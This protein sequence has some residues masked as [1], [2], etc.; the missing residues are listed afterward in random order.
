MKSIL[1]LLVAL[2]HSALIHAQNKDIDVYEKKDGDKTIVIA[3]NTSK[4]DYTV[5]LKITSEG[6]DIVPSANIESV[7]PAGMMKEMATITPRPGEAWSYGLEVSY[8]QSI[9]S[10][11]TST[12][13]T[14]TTTTTTK[15]PATLS[16]PKKPTAPE[17]SNANI[18]LYSK[19]GCSR[20]SF[21]KKQL[22]SKG[23]EFLE[24][25][26]QSDNPEVGNM[27][28]QLRN[29]GFNG[30]SVTMPV[31]REN[32]RYHYNIQDLQAFVDKLKS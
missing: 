21:I 14:N 8:K 29:N 11:P 9:K 26:T 16:A 4:S 13:N 18:V 7:V 15:Q 28:T 6:M 32:G 22:T 27:W 30:G 19:P 10:I 12:P 25:D 31:V 3:R 1:F 2:I 17:L 5:N 23:I 24:V 20:C